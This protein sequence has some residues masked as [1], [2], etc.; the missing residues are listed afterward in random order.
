MCLQEALQKC[1]LTLRKKHLSFSEQERSLHSWREN[2]G[3][4]KREWKS[5]GQSEK[6]GAVILLVQEAAKRT[7]RRLTTTQQKQMHP[8]EQHTG[9]RG[10]QV[11]SA[12]LCDQ[13][14]RN[15]KGT[16]SKWTASHSLA[17]HGHE[18]SSNAACSRLSCRVWVG[19]ACNAR[20]CLESA[21][22]GW[23]D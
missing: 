17:L 4:S 22:T 6:E 16:Q 23:I 13:S 15:A 8:L 20:R 11:Y 21:F 3:K 5:P 2:Y 14:I 12:C 7:T 9:G 10:T 19:A 1:P 18:V